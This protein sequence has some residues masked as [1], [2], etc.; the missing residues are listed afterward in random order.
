MSYDDYYGSDAIKCGHCSNCAC[1]AE[2]EVSDLKKKVAFLEK[3][4]S[5]TMARVGIQ[6]SADGK[7][8]PWRVHDHD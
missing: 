6:V 1:D 7:R 4:L 5:L 2:D 3:C 8:M